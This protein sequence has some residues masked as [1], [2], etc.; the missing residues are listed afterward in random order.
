MRRRRT[1]AS[2]LLH[3]QQSTCAECI[4]GLVQKLTLALSSSCHDEIESFLLETAMD[5]LRSGPLPPTDLAVSA[6]DIHISA[7][8]CRISA[9][10]FHAVTQD[11]PPAALANASFPAYRVSGPLVRNTLYFFRSLKSSAN[12]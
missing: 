9:L 6:W 3:A 1:V 2:S 7:V 8:V 5:P 12:A 4:V 10:P 11:V